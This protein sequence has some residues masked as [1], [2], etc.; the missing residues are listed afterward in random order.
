MNIFTV[1]IFTRLS[2]DYFHFNRNENA[3][4]KAA[5]IKVNEAIYSHLRF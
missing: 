5:F 1:E 2:V 4:N 3:A